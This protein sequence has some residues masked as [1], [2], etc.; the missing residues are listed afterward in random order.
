MAKVRQVV[1]VK[2]T[3][4]KTKTRRKA[5]SQSYKCPTCGSVIKK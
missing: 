2:N 1:V 5:Q 4:T 3:T